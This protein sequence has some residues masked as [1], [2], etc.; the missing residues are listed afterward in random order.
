MQRDVT[1][2]STVITLDI[3]WAPDFVIDAVAEQLVQA[4]VWA[5]WFV[6]HAGKM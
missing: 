1:E 4:G 6:T 2:Q 3:D 5:T